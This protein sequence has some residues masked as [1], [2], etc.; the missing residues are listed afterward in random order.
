VVK[1]EVVIL[2][3]MLRSFAIY[4]RT[5][6]ILSQIRRPPPEARNNYPSPIPC[7]ALVVEWPLSCNVLLSVQKV[8]VYLTLASLVVPIKSY[9]HALGRRSAISFRIIWR[10]HSVH[11]PQ[12]CWSILHRKKFPKVTK[13]WNSSYFPN[14]TPGDRLCGLVGQSSW[15]QI[16]TSRV[17]FPALT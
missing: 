11:P 10:D 15:L 7:I 8:A 9:Q 1:E 3:N 12:E 5:M 13:S 17:R 16:Q 14:L 2:N 6:K 4:E